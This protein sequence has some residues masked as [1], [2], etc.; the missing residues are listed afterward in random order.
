[1]SIPQIFESTLFDFQT[2][3]KKNLWI[4][5]LIS[6]SGGQDSINLLILWTNLL[7][8]TVLNILWCHHVWK[9]KDFYLFR[10]TFQISFILHQ[11]FFYTIFF[12][13]YFS[14][15][16]ARR[17]RYFSFLRIANYSGSKFVLTAHTQ[18]DNIETFF[19]H[20]FRGSGKFGLKILRKSQNFFADEC[21]QKFY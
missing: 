2:S 13:K 9:V 16:K 7:F 11:R 12:S 18:S 1:M 15:Q 6:F 4:N 8:S 3:K 5:C 19:I 14:E 17:F 21:S 20:L 10:H